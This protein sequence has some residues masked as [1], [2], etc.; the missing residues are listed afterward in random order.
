MYVETWS[1]INRPN[2]LSYSLSASMWWSEFK[3]H[4]YSKTTKFIYYENFHENFVYTDENKHLPEIDLHLRNKN[5]YL[6]IGLSGNSKNELLNRERKKYS[7]I[8]FWIFPTFHLHFI[9]QVD[10]YYNQYLNALRKKKSIFGFNTLFINLNNHYKKHKYKMVESLMSHDLDNY[11]TITYRDDETNKWKTRVSNLD[12]GPSES[13]IFNLSVYKNP[14]IDLVCE[15]EY[16]IF[17]ITEKTWKPILLEQIFL[18]CGSKNFHT[19]LEEMGF[20]LYRKIFDYS[21]DT[22]DDMSK[23][24]EGIT[25]NLLKI[26]KIKYSKIYNQLYDDIIYNKKRAIEICN[27]REYIPKPYLYFSDKILLNHNENSDSNLYTHGIFQLVD[28]EMI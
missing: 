21:F 12:L 23:R 11:G 6:F 13:G 24:I 14:L 16:D 2:I 3:T 17:R 25:Q 4:V 7:N 1:F 9:Q 5:Q 18:V 28:K 22:E 10:S 26:K 19:N 8:R 20:K 27:N 15:S